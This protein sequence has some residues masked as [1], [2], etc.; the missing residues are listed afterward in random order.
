[1]LPLSPTTKW[2]G[3]G[4][5]KNMEQSGFEITGQ[6]AQVVQI[7]PLAGPPAG[8]DFG[9][10]RTWCNTQK[11]FWARI[12][13]AF[14]SG[15]SLEGLCYCS[16]PDRWFSCANQEGHEGRAATLERFK[17][18]N[19]ERQAKKDELAAKMARFEQRRMKT[20]CLTPQHCIDGFVAD[21]ASRSLEVLTQC[22][23]PWRCSDCGRR[24]H[25]CLWGVTTLMRAPGCI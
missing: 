16:L 11:Y 13:S 12:L 25:W 18:E 22:W 4:L 17:K 3:I 10:M 1:M 8:T 9:F 21:S 15:P 6:T 19:Q 20:V 2:G 14:W 7:W 5:V 24:F 23:T